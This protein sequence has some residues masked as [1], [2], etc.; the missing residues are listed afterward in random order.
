MTTTEQISQELFE[1]LEKK[2]VKDVFGH[3]T[4]QMLMY[5]PNN[6][7]RF[8]VK[9]LQN[10]FPDEATALEEGEVKIHETFQLY[11]HGELHTA[12]VREYDDGTVKR[13][14]NTGAFEPESVALGNHDG[15]LR[16]HVTEGNSHTMDKIRDARVAHNFT[17]VH[18][19]PVAEAAALAKAAAEAAQAA[20]GASDD[21]AVEIKGGDGA[22]GGDAA[23][24]AP[25]EGS[26]AEGGRADGEG[27]DQEGGGG[28]NPADN[29]A[30]VGEEETAAAAAATAA[31]GSADDQHKAAS[32]DTDAV[33][34]L[35]DNGESA[36]PVRTDEEVLDEMGH[37]FPVLEKHALFSHMERWEWL[38]VLRALD[39][40]HC[41][42]YD[43]V[44]KQDVDGPEQSYF[45]I[46]E[47]GTVEVFVMRDVEPPKQPEKTAAEKEEEE[48]EAMR[49]ANLAAMGLKDDVKLKKKQGTE[50]RIRDELRKAEREAAQNAATKRA[51][52]VLATYGR[53]DSFGELA[54][55]YPCK[56]EASVLV[57]SKKV[58]AADAG[59]AELFCIFRVGLGVELLA[60]HMGLGLW[61]RR[62]RCAHRISSICAHAYA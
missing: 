60:F 43:M 55:M 26:L 46:V 36:E 3:I 7:V 62:P 50:Q 9:T 56:R 30:A 6:V 14:I 48:R 19:D 42:K 11:G 38:Q 53:G 39:E 31:A 15:A 13:S 54:L 23:D 25:E 17:S 47:E 35:E 1:F 22:G 61:R 44:C 27:M 8:I 21:P 2:N 51:K 57:T 10:D 37:L 45:Y 40:V 5:K 4:E 41:R 59:G 49:K 32:A 20:R 33:G 52:K 58:T 24:G 12:A 18:G 28:A 16:I 29:T 34:D